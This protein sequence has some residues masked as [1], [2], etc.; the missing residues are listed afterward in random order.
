MVESLESQEEDF[1]GDKLCDREPVE[2][3]ENK[4]DVFMRTF[5]G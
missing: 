3:E 2:S 5:V 4:S 1:E